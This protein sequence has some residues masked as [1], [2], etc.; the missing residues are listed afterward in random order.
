[1]TV[2]QPGFQFPG[3][4]DCFSVWP[5]LQTSVLEQQKESGLPGDGEEKPSLVSR[6]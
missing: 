2:T 3:G 5:C 4:A 1:M 6:G